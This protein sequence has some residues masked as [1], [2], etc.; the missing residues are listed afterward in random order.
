MC[1]DATTE[2]DPAS[3]ATA[4]SSQYKTG[5]HDTRVA[6]ATDELTGPAVRRVD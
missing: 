2:R 6:S 4:V 1:A 3:S 5:L